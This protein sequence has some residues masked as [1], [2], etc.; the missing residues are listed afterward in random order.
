MRTASFRRA[1][2]A[3][4]A[5]ALADAADF[6]GVGNV[7]PGVNKRVGVVSAVNKG[8]DAAAVAVPED[9]DVFHFQMFD[10]VFYGG[11]VPW[12]WLISAV[13]RRNEALPRC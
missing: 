2:G 6:V 1:A 11:E 12:Q 3:F 7:Q 4:A 9:D 13:I 10:G 5:V 8:V